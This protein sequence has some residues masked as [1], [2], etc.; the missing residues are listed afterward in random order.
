[1]LDLTGRKFGKLTVQRVASRAKHGTPVIWICLCDC[2]NLTSVPA[3]HLANGHTKS[4]GCL[5]VPH[6]HASNKRSAEYMCWT[7]M[8]QR[9]T[10]PSSHAFRNYGGRGIGVCERWRHSF[11]A[12]LADM[13]GKPHP[14]LTI[15][16]IDNN[17]NYEPKNCKWATYSENLRNRRSFQRRKV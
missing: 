13:G 4:C 9:C 1:M 15:E 14:S 17:G 3:N 6:G 16:R 8:I 5:R 10:N 11:A 12:F 2:G 7:S